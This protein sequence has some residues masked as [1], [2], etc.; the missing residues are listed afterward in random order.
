MRDIENVQTA[1]KEQHYKVDT[2]GLKSVIYHH[3]TI[4]TVLKTNIHLFKQLH[5]E[6]TY[7]AAATATARNMV[8]VANAFEKLTFW[9]LFLSSFFLF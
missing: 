3:F 6:Y 8:A 4:C 2:A 5:P 9:S 1:N 7:V